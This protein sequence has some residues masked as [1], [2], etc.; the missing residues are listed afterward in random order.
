VRAFAR[1]GVANPD[2]EQIGFYTGLGVVLDRVLLPN[3]D[4]RLGVA[5]AVA[6]NGHAYRDLQAS[7]GE[8]VNDHETAIEVTWRFQMNPWLAVQ[9]DL[10]YVV[11]PG[12]SPGIADALVVGV[13][14]DVVRG[15]AF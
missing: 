5:I 2:V 6:R 4:N 11:N 13:R 3:L 7:L 12:T 15:L 9:P 14:F 10:Q 1:V 8:A